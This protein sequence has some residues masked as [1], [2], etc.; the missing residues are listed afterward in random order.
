MT[1]RYVFLALGMTALTVSSASAAIET[2]LVT[3]TNNTATPW[4]RVVFY[5]QADTLVDTDRFNAIRFVDDL[6]LQS[7]PRSPVVKSILDAP[8]N[9]RLAFTFF[10]S[11]LLAP[12]GSYEFSLTVDNPFNERFTFG[13]RVV[14]GQTNIPTPTGLALL[15]LP[16][17]AT[18]RRRR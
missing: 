8:I 10:E 13:W 4:A 5:F 14:N 16:A 15:A 1:S 3:I 17:V 6:A 18:L 9:D 2:R 12:N 11:S 7:S